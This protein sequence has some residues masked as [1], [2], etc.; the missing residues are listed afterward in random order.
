MSSS[1]SGIDAQDRHDDM[2]FVDSSKVLVVCKSPIN[3]VVI[4]KIVERCGLRPISESPETAAPALQ[5]LSPGTVV[6]DGG[7]D[8]RDCDP[9]LAEISSVRRLMGGT[10]P[11]VVMLSTRN[12][13]LQAPIRH[14]VVDAVVTKPITPEGLQP[15]IERLA[16][17]AR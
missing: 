4:C 10:T 13:S 2:P 12:R 17:R 9:L 11:A 16:K 8:N 6:L 3:R 5:A 7:A 15:V 1:S 14:N